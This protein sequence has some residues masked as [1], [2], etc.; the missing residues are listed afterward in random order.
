MKT[1]KGF[2]KKYGSTCFF[3]L[4]W[5]LL[6]V[7]FIVIPII[8][9]IVL[10]FTDFDMVRMPNFVG[11][12]NYLNLFLDDEIFTKSLSNTLFYALVTGPIGYLISYVVAWLINEISSKFWRSL[13]TLVFYSPA[14]AGNAYMLWN[15]IFNGDSYGLLNSILV[16]LGILSKPV[17]W[18]TDPAYNS[19]V[20]VIVTLWMSMGVG[21]LSFVAGFKQLNQE[22]FEAGAIDGVR[23]RWQ[24]LWYI[25]L[26]QMVPQLKIG[27]VLAISGAFA[28]GGVNAALT[29]NPSTD[30][31][32]HTVLLHMTDYGYVRYEMGYASTIAV[33]LFVIMVGSWFLINTV[34]SRFSAD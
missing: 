17:Q 33:V 8:S 12:K 31:S 13:L 20:V 15:Y 18:L 22:L 1:K 16:D 7:I 14:L 26:P 6:F 10:S 24:E 32:T 4:P 28:V 3:L 9:A 30:Y 5:L 34:L 19:M 29:G 25:T 23:N 11:F 2:F 27:A 21:F